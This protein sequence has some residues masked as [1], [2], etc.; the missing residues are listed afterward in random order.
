VRFAEQSYRRTLT[1][2]RSSQ[3]FVG[4]KSA[5]CGQPSLLTL[6]W[7]CYVRIV[8]LNL[9]EVLNHQR[10]CYVCAAARSRCEHT[11]TNLVRAP[12]L[13][14]PWLL[15]RG[16]A[17]QP[18]FQLHPWCGLWRS[19]HP[20]SRLLSAQLFDHL[21]LPVIQYLL[22]QVVKIAKR[23]QQVKP[24]PTRRRHINATVIC[25]Q[26]HYIGTDR[27]WYW[28]HGGLQAVRACYYMR[29][30]TGKTACSVLDTI[31]LLRVMT[32]FG[33]MPAIGQAVWTKSQM[34]IAQRFC[35]SL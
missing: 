16:V 25:T 18:C 10:W 15:I 23:P 7:F 5:T 34:L 32:R 2:H 26:L 28:H 22:G 33:P 6:R 29:W 12:F 13:A 14:N 30:R 20:S 17:E 27:L 1:S 3:R 35:P 24:C 21:L 11:T 31:I 19:A 8:V 9:V 4:S